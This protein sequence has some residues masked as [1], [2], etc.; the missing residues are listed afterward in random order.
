MHVFTKSQDGCYE[1]N[2]NIEVCLKVIRISPELV[3]AAI[4]KPN[5]QS[6]SG[7][8][9]ISARVL[10][11]LKSEIMLPLMLL[12]RQSMNDGATLST[13]TWF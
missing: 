6:A 10:K 5:D 7:P 13:F 9:G 3:E 12:F 8:D 1:T 2:E 11:E 4:D